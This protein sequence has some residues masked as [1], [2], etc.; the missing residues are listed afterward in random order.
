MSTLMKQRHYG[1]TDISLCTVFC[2]QGWSVSILLGCPHPAACP[3]LN[4]GA[5]HLIF[6][7]ANLA[8]AHSKMNWGENELKKYF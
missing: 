3:A 5:P 2:G 8:V 6:P 4:A 7:S 1:V